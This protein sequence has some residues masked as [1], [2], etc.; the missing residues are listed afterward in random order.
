MVEKIKESNSPIK[1]M[2]EKTEQSNQKS[3]SNITQLRQIPS[4]GKK[5]NKKQ[6]DQPPKIAFIYQS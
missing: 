5:E 6:Q 3:G 2:V 1:H 4:S